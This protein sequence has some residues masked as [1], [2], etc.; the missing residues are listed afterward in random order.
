MKNLMVLSSLLMANLV[1]ANAE[2]PA[3]IKCVSAKVT[4]G[5][6]KE[7]EITKLNTP[8]PES[9]IPD[10]S[11]TEAGDENGVMGLIFSNECDNYYVINLSTEDL[12]DLNNKRLTKI[13][14]AL[15]YADVELSDANNGSEME[16]TTL[17]TCTLN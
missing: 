1:W 11:T 17:L 6:V 12:I 2:V 15:N 14:G 5:A 4:S 10:T 8:N 3:K 7:F 9:T 13:R 16:E